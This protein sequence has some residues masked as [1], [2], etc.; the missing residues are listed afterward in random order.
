MSE[1][2]CLIEDTTECDKYQIQI[3]NNIRYSEIT[4]YRIL[5]GIQHIP[6]PTIQLQNIKHRKW[7]NF[8][9]MFQ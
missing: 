8:F 2:F 7:D 9:L 1:D 5:F 3:Q 4:K 6:I